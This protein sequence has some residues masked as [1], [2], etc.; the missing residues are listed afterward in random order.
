MRPIRFWGTFGM[1]DTIWRALAKMRSSEDV[2]QWH[3]CFSL[4]E[5]TLE[6]GTTARGDLM[7][8]L[9]GN[10]WRYREASSAELCEAVATRAW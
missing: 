5:R 2:G 7:R 3:P 1:W 4:R 8:R 6:G 9:D 10:V